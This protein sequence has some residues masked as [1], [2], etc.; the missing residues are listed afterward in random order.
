MMDEALNMINIASWGISLLAIIIGG[1]G[2]I[3]TMIMSVY[4]RTREI[5]V[6]R[7]VGWKKGRILGMIMGE[8]LILTLTSGII[9]S[10]IGVLTIELFATLGILGQIIPAY[11]I[12]TFIQA[13][14]LAIVVGLIGGF[15]PAYSASRLPPTEA[16]RYE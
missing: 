2:I 11:N 8:S 16:L 13:F 1:I 12:E 4:E 10:L 3:N 6:L 9:G 7:A 15:Y 14:A 5:G